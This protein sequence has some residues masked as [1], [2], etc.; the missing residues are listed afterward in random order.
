MT[1]TP[2]TAPPHTG[3]ADLHA[4]LAAL[5]AQLTPQTTLLQAVALLPAHG[6]AWHLKPDEEES[7]HIVALTHAGG[8]QLLTWG[9]DPAMGLAGLIGLPAALIFEVRITNAIPAQP[10]PASPAP[11]PVAAAAESLAEATA[12]EVIEGEIFEPACDPPHPTT[13]LSDEQ[14]AVA[15]EMVRQLSAEQR[16]AFTIAY[17]DAFKVPREAKSIIPTITQLRHL[18][19]IDRFTVE[20][21]GGISE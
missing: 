1:Q 14:R 20:A 11:L 10:E 4:A 5:Q 9:K 7:G 2:H 12:G 8:D 16:K 13:P 17:R 21:A 3:R 15:V 6:L 19:F 18:A